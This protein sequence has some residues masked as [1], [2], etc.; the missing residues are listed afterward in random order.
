[1]T[2]SISQ[3][4]TPPVPT[5]SARRR[6]KKRRLDSTEKAP[7]LALLKQLAQWYP[8]LFGP[9]L[10]PLKRGIFHD[11]LAAHGSSID[12]ETLKL[13]LALHTRST[14]YL[15]AIAAG[16]PRYDLQGQA[17]EAVAPE[18]VYLALHAVFRRRQLRTPE[19][20]L[21]PELCNRIVRAF[22]N[23]GLT[24]EAYIAL[25]RQHNEHTNTLLE[26]ALAQ[27][28]EQDAKAEA[29]LRAY[30]TSGSTDTAQ[31][32]NMYGLSQRTVTQQLQYAQRIQ[33]RRPTQLCEA[34]A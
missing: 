15:S 9:K 2:T 26:Q 6:L 23:S 31:F 24:R 13:A 11:L 4:E 33:N 21:T 18:H 17:V 28:A 22:H 7:V 29:L 12:E 1:M 14:R 8:R 16:Q 32:A 25:V 27:A 20:D 30:E 3:P 5:L 34:S 19:E 10:L